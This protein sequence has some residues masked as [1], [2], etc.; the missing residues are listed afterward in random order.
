MKIEKI[1]SVALTDTG[2]DV[3]MT[4]E[5]GDTAIAHL[6]ENWVVQVVSRIENVNGTQQISDY[7]VIPQ[8]V[9]EAVA[10]INN[11]SDI[12]DALLMNGVWLG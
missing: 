6:D 8:P 2:Y 4:T 9:R 5:T 12:C 3:M 11:D 1:V 10:K 7:S